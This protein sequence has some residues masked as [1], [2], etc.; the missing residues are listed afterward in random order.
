[1]WLWTKRDAE[2]ETA[3]TAP[4]EPDHDERPATE[5][6]E[7]LPPRCAPCT[8]VSCG[9]PLSRWFPHSAVLRIFR[10]RKVEDTEN[11][12]VVEE[13]RG[14]FKIVS[15]ELSF[16]L[17]DEVAAQCQALQGAKRW[18]EQ[19]MRTSE[20]DSEEGN[21]VE[22]MEVAF[23]IP[24]TTQEDLDDLKAWLISHEHAETLPLDRLVRLGHNTAYLCTDEGPT[25]RALRAQAILVYLKTVHFNPNMAQDIAVHSTLNPPVYRLIERYHFPGYLEMT[26][27]MDITIAEYKHSYY[28]YDDTYV[29]RLESIRTIAPA[30]TDD[31]LEVDSNIYDKF[32]SGEFGPTTDVSYSRTNSYGWYAGN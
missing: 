2:Q 7:E 22:T 30:I 32:L 29:E 11:E 5:Q 18:K 20:E 13:Y 14:R 4:R 15:G 24:E 25:N 6:R 1:M 9:V 8:R 19:S 17:T 31:G 16:H 28:E 27:P 12:G 26:D 21:A 10:L 23:E 3:A